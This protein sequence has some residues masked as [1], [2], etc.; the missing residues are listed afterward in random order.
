[1]VGDDGPTHHGVFD[2]SFLR[3]IPNMI[4]MAP[5]DEE[6]LRHMLFTAIH[7]KGPAAI[8]YPRGSGEDVTLSD[9][10]HQLEIGKGEVLAEGDDILLLP[11]GNRVHPA[12]R[13]M[14]GL[15]KVGVNAAVI[16][17]RFI[18]PMDTDLI[19]SWAKRTGRVLTIED[20]VR[21]G[22]FGSTVLELFSRNR[23][24]DVHTCCLG[25]PD[26]FIEHG[27]QKNLWKDNSLDSPAIIRAALKLL[28]N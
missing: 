4:L 20:N 9:N 24:F 27:P 3:Y 14:E 13:A 22:G 23:L 25:H 15:K 12:L 7:H 10:L 16:N 21:Q 11:I 2:L 17:P 28:G 18:K 19:C 8:R 5:K 6:E 1:V 26:F